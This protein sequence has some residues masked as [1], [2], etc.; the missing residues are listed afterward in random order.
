MTEPERDAMT[1][2]SRSI[3]D[4]GRK[5]QR[6][7]DSFVSNEGIGLFVVADGMAENDS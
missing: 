3:S 5:R 6:N 2:E 1:V 7:E 4:V